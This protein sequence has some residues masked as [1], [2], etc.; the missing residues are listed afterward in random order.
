MKI[1]R[2]LGGSRVLIAILLAISLAA[3]A[4]SSGSPAPTAP[5]SKSEAPAKPAEATKA[6]AAA[7]ANSGSKVKI[8]WMEWITPE[9]GE[10]RAKSIIDAFEKDNPNISVERVS[11]PFAQVHDKVVALNVAKQLPDV[12]NMNMP[13]TVEFAEQGILE[14][15]NPYLDKSDKAWVDQLVKAPMTPWK[16]KSYLLPLTSIPFLLFYNADLLKEA[17][18]TAPPKTWD[19]MREMAIKTTKPE[20][21]QYA[22]T[23]GMAAK[24]PYNGAAIELFHL[25]YEQGTTTIKDGKANINSPEAVKAVQFYVDLVNKDKVYSPGTLTN[26]ENDKVEAFASGRNTFMVSNVAHIAVLK[27]RNPNLNFGVAP[28]P[29]AVTT[30]T[31]LTGWNLGMSGQS[32][33]KEAAWTFMQWLASPKGNALVAAASGQ[34]PG[35]SAASV[36]AVQSDPMLKTAAEILKDPRVMA[37]DAAAPQNFDLWRIMVEQV[38]EALQNKKTVQQ[39]MDEAAKGWNDILA[40]YK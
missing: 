36:P 26:L 38:Q 6:P 12:L 4:C 29:K 28:L 5:A 37:E 20:K 34:L 31:R 40:K 16:G 11:L 9:I 8:Q 19:E 23:S 22:F 25:I 27:S 24:S 7:P 33:N 21:N 30:G 39:A 14:P 2:V 32:K 35:N 10:D 18:Y 13:W 3:V 15:L 17:G 1:T